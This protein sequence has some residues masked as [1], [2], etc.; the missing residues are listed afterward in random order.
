MKKKP[1]NK[2]YYPSKKKGKIKKIKKGASTFDFDETLGK[3][4]KQSP[5]KLPL[6]ALIG[7][8]TMLVGKGIDA[9]GRHRSNKKAKK[10]ALEQKKE[11]A[12]DKM[13]MKPI[14]TSNPITKKGGISDSF[15]EGFGESLGGAAASALVGG[16]ADF[17][18]S[19]MTKKKKEKKSVNPTKGFSNIKIGRNSAAFKMKGFGGFKSSP[20]T[21]KN[22]KEE[23]K[24]TR[25]KDTVTKT[26]GGRTSTYKRTSTRDNKDGSKTY[27]FTN[28]LGNT[29]TETHS[30]QEK[31]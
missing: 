6:A 1:I 2:K 30:K 5:A 12:A 15:K 31:K 26:K 4:A 13:K 17:A 10:F 27:T 7:A 22:K 25:T 11:G 28:D 3:A 14:K 29:I 21:D 24:T 9:I 19:K 16:V 8:G 18:M 20:M 23:V